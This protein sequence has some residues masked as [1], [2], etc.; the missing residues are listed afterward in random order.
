[1]V[2]SRKDRFFEYWLEKTGGRIK[3]FLELEP[4]PFETGQ[5]FVWEPPALQAA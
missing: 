3:F 1:M 2:D 4:L 5:L